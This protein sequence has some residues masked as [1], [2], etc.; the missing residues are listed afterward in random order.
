MITGWFSE[1]GELADAKPS[2]VRYGRDAARFAGATYDPTSHYRAAEVFA[3]HQRME[4]TPPRLRAISQHQV[5][6]LQQGFEALD[7]DPAIARVEPVPAARRGGFLA[8][9]A[10]RAAEVVRALRGRGV[11]TDSRGDVLRLGPAPYL[12]DQQLRDGIQALAEALS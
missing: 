1:F 2:E 10:P 3:F 5:G 4:L 11:F 6:V 7:V 8:I 12:A 9:R